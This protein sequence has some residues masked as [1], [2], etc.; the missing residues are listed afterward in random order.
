MKNNKTLSIALAALFTTTMASAEMEAS[1]KVTIEHAAL[2]T[3]GSTIGSTVTNTGFT[4]FKDEIKVQLFADGDISDNTTFHVEAAGYSDQSATA[5]YQGIQSDTQ[6]DGFRELYVDTSATGG[7]W[8]LR[9]GKQQIVWGTADGM[10]LLDAINPT[11]YSEM[12]QNQMEDS[13]IT[14]WAANAEKNFA[15]GSN[16]QLVLS[17]GKPN[18]MAGLTNIANGEDYDVTVT[19]NECGLVNGGVGSDCTAMVPGVAVAG[20]VDTSN[21]GATDGNHVFMMKGVDSISGAS[22]GILNIVPQL[23][24][25]A[26]TFGQLSAGF[27]GSNDNAGYHLQNWTY[28]DVNQFVTNTGNGSGFGGACPY[29][30]INTAQGAASP[31]SAYCL[32]SIAQDTNANVTNLID[33]SAMP[34]QGVVLMT[35]ATPTHSGIVQGAGGAVSGDWDATTPDSAFEY[36][37][38]AAFA[39]FATFNSAKTKYIRQGAESKTNMALRFSDS[40]KGGLNYSFNLLRG[41]DQNPYIDLEWQNAAGDTLEVELQ[42]DPSPYDTGMTTVRVKDSGGN[43]HTGDGQTPVY[44]YNGSGAGASAMSSIT[45]PV[46]LV[47]KEKQADI[48]Q[49][50]GS[51]DTS[52]ESSSLGPVV[53]R[54][55]YLYQTDVRTPIVDKAQMSIGN[56]TEAFSSMTGDR[57]K[58]V[59]GAD[60]TVLTNMMVSAQI[61]GDNN[62]DYVDT[63]STVGAHTGDK[64]TADMASMSMQNQYQKAIKNKNFYSLF[65]SKPFGASGENRWNNI[66]MIEEGVGENAYWNRFD[67]DFGISDDVVATVEVNTYGGNVNTQFGQ[68]DKSDNM[69]V[70]VKYSF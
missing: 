56:I 45:N 59:L 5:N 52:F 18:V 48:T 54:G 4:G 11:D 26:S 43:W 27:A 35:G 12:A 15:D 38:N 24:E 46:T 66:V 10:K 47:L 16:V 62:L 2:L 50:G 68:M 58:Y 31:S 70:G 22:N 19:R 41:A 64:Y 1:G 40:T 25:V 37:P 57:F 39:T 42:T 6:R 53:L 28:A 51:F 21:T 55:E 20:S 63:T 13:R 60:I 3:D 67:A 44:G 69:Q 32:N 61:I 8:D 9:L 17:E 14:V 23:A 36:M 7:G 34:T 33:A 49:L 30:A 65:F 29:W